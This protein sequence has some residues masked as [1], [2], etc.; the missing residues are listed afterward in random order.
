VYLPRQGV[1]L[2]CAGVAPVVTHCDV[3]TVSCVLGLMSVYL[4]TGD[5]TGLCAAPV[6]PHCDNVIVSCVLGLMSMYRGTGDVIGLG[7]EPVLN[8]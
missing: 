2:L 7:A 3:V 6:V 4:G 5:V 1:S 8:R